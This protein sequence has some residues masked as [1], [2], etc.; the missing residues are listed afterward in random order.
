MTMHSIDHKNQSR[1][2]A[3][4]AYYDPIFG[5]NG[6]LRSNFHVLVENTV[7]KLLTSSING[8]VKVTGVQV[9]GRLFAT[10]SKC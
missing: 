4:I 6:T 2:D 1:S 10:I 9:R 7:T 5:E 8:V 3:R